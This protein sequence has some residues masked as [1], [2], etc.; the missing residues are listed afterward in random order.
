METYLTIQKLRAALPKMIANAFYAGSNSAQEIH[1]DK[2]GKV[3]FDDFF[4]EK[5][6]NTALEKFDEILSWNKKDE[7]N[8]SNVTT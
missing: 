4:C 3:I 7:D 1:L 5:A 8:K 6:I 2:D